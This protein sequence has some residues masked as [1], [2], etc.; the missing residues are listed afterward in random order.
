MIVGLPGSACAQGGDSTASPRELAITIGSLVIAAGALVWLWRKDVIRPGSFRRHPG[1]QAPRPASAMA[2]LALMLG[3]FVLSSLAQI[4]AVGAIGADPEH[5][6][7]VRQMGIVNLVVGPVSVIVAVSAFIAAHRLDT[8]PRFRLSIKGFGLGLLLSLFVLP[9]AMAASSVTLLIATA[10]GHG[11]S[12]AIAHDT[13]NAI[14]AP[15]AGVWKWVLIVGAVVV[16]PIVEEVL[17]RGL[18]QSALAAILPGRWGKWGAVQIASALFT[19]AHTTGGVEW[20]SLPAIAV[21]GLS[22]AVAYERT[23]RIAV[24][25]AMHVAFNGANVL[26]ALFIQ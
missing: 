10:L 5:G 21:L 1:T 7:T 3:C 2:L 26:L 19:L 20:H 22:M 18:L 14:L 4:I 15:E 8:I 6:L 11:P 12:D 24:P 25:I 17:F 9:M 16:T 13:L 23:G